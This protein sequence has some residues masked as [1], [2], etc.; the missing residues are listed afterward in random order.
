[1]KRYLYITSG[2][3]TLS[4]G[5]LGIV[6]PGLP[7]TPFILLTG[8]LFAKGSPELHR[9]LLNNRLTGRYI[10]KVNGGFSIKEMLISLG[11]MWCMI[12]FTTFVVFRNNET[13]QY[14]M[15]GL[16]CIGTLSQIFV[17]RKKKKK[18]KISL[19]MK[20]EGKEDIK[21]LKAS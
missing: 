6:T 9:W 2:L 15:L 4:L 8:I 19:T 16:G 1:M 18:V 7:T 5:L 11:I 12:C 14:I 20:N 13:M 21:N 3:I 17:L 10:K